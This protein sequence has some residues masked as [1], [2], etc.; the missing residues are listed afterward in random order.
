M[1]NLSRQVIK[2]NR[3]VFDFRL[4]ISNYQQGGDAEGKQNQTKQQMGKRRQK[5]LKA[6]KVWVTA[7]YQVW[8]RA[9]TVGASSL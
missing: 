8:Q 6:V 5:S 1:C 4:S 9:K 3:Q 2:C 7:K